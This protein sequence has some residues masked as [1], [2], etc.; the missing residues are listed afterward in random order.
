MTDKQILEKVDEAMKLG[1][2]Q[3]LEEVYEK[4]RDLYNYRIRIYNNDYDH[5]ES[6]QYKY[7]LS[8]DAREFTTNFNMTLDR[9][10]E[11]LKEESEE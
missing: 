2:K 10:K 1:R 9:I 11:M 8:R 4:I 5:A 6:E 7:D 3:A